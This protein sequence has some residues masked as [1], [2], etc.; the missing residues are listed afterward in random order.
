MVGK[1][2]FE[3]AT[4]R[5]Q[6]ECSTK[7]SHFPINGVPK[8]SRTPNL[9]IRSQTLYPVELW[10][11]P[12]QNIYKL[13]LA[14]KNGGFSWNRTNDTK[15]FS[16]VL[17]QLS[18]EATMAVPTGIEPAIPRVTGE[19]DNRYTTEP[20]VAGEGF[21]P[22]TFGLWAQRATRLLYPA[23][24]TINGGGKGIRTPA[25]L[26]RPPGFQDQSLQPDLGIPPSRWC[27]GPD[28]NRH[29]I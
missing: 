26:S 18:Y 3:P 13:R 5:S 12:V 21:E 29:G 7:L 14:F 20:L 4:T 24:L 25:P 10:G 16:L 8:R 6:T 23:I 19:C 15:I 28:L 22:P 17:C 27:L 11:Q 1:T 9:L 2:G